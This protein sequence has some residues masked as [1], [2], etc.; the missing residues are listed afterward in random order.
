MQQYKLKRGYKPEIERIKEIIEAN[1]PVQPTEKD[2]K[3]VFSYGAIKH[4]EAWIA[5]KRLFLE[6]VPNKEVISDEEV[7]DTNKR[8]RKFL[9]EATGYTSKQRVKTAKKDVQ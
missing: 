6:T 4:F 2:G 8:F 9:D 7:L 1:F 5:D 3:L